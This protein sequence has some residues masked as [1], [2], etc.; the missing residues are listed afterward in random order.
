MMP[1]DE[2]RH[3]AG[4]RR[5]IA[6][7]LAS[8][9]SRN[10]RLQEEN[11]DNGGETE[12]LKQWGFLSDYDNTEEIA[13]FL[14]PVD[15]IHFRLACIESSVLPP[16]NRISASTRTTATT[17]L[18]PWLMS[19]FEDNK[20]TICEY[21]DPIFNNEKYL[22]KSCKELVGATIRFSKGGWL[23]LSK[24][25]K[26]IFCY[27]PFTREMIRLPD[28]PDDYVL[29]G[30]SFS[31]VPTS[32]DCVVIVISKCWELEGHSEISFMV[33]KPVTRATRWTVRRFSYQG[34][35]GTTLCRVL[36]IRFSIRELSTA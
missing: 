29:G 24:G 2:N 4:R 19:I 21:L 11:M 31:S 34:D 8:Q 18:S 27:N 17:C 3:V 15:C 12:E 33:T 23:L 6:D 26:T 28:V 14:H 10:A 13:K 9:D 1:T 22:M 20:K 25:K 35:N 36:T 32:R 16:L 30:M 5:R 7:V